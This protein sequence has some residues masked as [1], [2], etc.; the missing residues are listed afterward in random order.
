ML[1]AY[2]PFSTATGT[3]PTDARAATE[4]L[5]KALKRLAPVGVD[6]ALVVAFALVGVFQKIIGRRHALEALLGGGVAV[7]LIRV[8]RLGQLAESLLDLG[9]GGAALDTQFLIRIACH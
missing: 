8:Q 1:P 5:A 3:R 6:L 4:A 9:V 2:C 7:V